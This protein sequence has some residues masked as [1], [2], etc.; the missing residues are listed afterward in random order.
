MT[1]ADSAQFCV[2]LGHRLRARRLFLEMTQEQLAALTGLHVQ[3]IRKYEI[4][5]SE[6]QAFTL[7]RAARALECSA[8]YLLGRG[9]AEAR[10]AMREYAELLSDPVIAAI[11]HRLR[12]MNGPQRKRARMLLVAGEESRI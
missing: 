2:R 1:R 11:L 3:Q 12:K 8:D 9:E 6:P 7:L 4:G 10:P 5:E